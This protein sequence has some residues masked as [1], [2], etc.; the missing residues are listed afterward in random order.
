MIRCI[1]QQNIIASNILFSVPNWFM[2]G[3]DERKQGIFMGLKK[4]VL[5]GFCSPVMWFKI[6]RE[7]LE[8]HDAFEQKSKPTHYS[9]PLQFFF[10]YISTQSDIWC[11]QCVTCH[12][13]MIFNFFFLHFRFNLGFGKL[14]FFDLLVT[15]AVKFH[16]H[17]YFC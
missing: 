15:E 3:W 12:I 16:S 11:N 9:W 7:K 14:S 2:I 10:C 8:F 6:K 4:E 1:T 17:F 13:T 5:A